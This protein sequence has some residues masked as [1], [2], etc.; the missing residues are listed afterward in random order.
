MNHIADWFFGGFVNWKT[1]LTSLTMGVLILLDS[2]GYI[3]VSDTERQTIIA[4][5][6][7]IFGWFAK[8]SNSVGKPKDSNSVGKSTDA[9]LNDK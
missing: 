4:A 6:V 3:H 2:A 9:T 7:I 1:T 5:L 8:D